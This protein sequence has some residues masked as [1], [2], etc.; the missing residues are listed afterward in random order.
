[1][2]LYHVSAWVQTRATDVLH[3]S[4]YDLPT[5]NLADGWLPKLREVIHD[6][7]AVDTGRQFPVEAVTIISISPL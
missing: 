1:M 2:S 6:C 5:P 3:D 4:M 7:V